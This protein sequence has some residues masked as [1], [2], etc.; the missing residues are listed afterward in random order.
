MTN[1]LVEMMKSLW[2][3]PGLQAIKEYCS[4]FGLSATACVFMD[5]IE[6][7]SMA[8]YMPS[9]QDILHTRKKTTGIVELAFEQKV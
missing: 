3:D 2:S 7:I 1:D 5:N 4:E 6:K 8:D 9:T